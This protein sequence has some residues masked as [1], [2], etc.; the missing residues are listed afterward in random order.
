MYRKSQVH[1][2]TPPVSQTFRR[3]RQ[4][5]HKLG[6]SLGC[7]VRPYL[8]L[9]PLLLLLLL[10]LLLVVVVLLLAL[11]TQ[12]AKLLLLLLLILLIIII[13]VFRKM[14]IGF[15]QIPCHFHLKNVGTYR[16][17]L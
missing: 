14:C 8:L 7:L 12:G 15:M 1:L 16:L 5:V 17:G 13:K 10:L 9:P 2:Y 11:L 3:L 4:E 6:D